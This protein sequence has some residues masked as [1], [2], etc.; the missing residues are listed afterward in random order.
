M[1]PATHTVNTSERL[2]AL[3]QL[4]SKSEYD[5]AAVVVPSEDQHYS[6]YPAKCDERRA[7][8]S[9]FTGSAGCAVITQND[10]FLFTDG[11]YFLQAEKQLDKNW[12]LMKQGLPDV[13]TWQEF[14]WKKLPKCTRIGVDPTIVTASD[15]DT[16]QKNLDP[17]ESRLVSLKHNLVDLVWTD[18]PPRPANGIFPL[19]VKYAGESHVRKIERL[20]EEMRKREVHAIVVNMLDEVAWLINLRGSDIDYNPVFFAYA[21]LTPEKAQIFLNPEQIDDAL[22]K[23]LGDDVDIHPY[24]S[25]FSYL[26]DIGAEIGLHK[27]SKALVGDKASLAIVEAMGAD[28]VIVAR[29]PVTDLKAVKNETEVEGFRQSHIRDGVALVRYFAWLEEQMNND[30]ELNECEVADQL[31]RYRSELALFR[32]LSFPTISATGSNG[33]IIHYQPD[34]NDCAIVRKDQIYLC[35]SGAQFTD[36]TTDVTRTWHFGTPTAEERRAFTRVLQG[37]IAIDTAIFPNGTTG[38]IIDSFA[39]RPLWEDGLDFRHGTGHGVG[40]FLNVHEGPHGIGVRIAYNS[41]P[42]KSGMTVSDEPGYYADGRFGIRIENV[43]VV[44]E[45]KTPNNFGQKGYLK[46]EH[47]TM[48]PIQKNLVDTSLLSPK[49]RSWL[50]TYHAEILEKLSPL[51]KTDERALTWLQR[52]CSPL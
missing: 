28:N 5:V 51:L 52:E 1:A 8:M 24:D 31:E 43:V 7:F 26:S 18:R 48:C 14:L 9:G 13:P 29:S 38:Y 41:T 27:K 46:F 12:T 17:L 19:D 45:A 50:D 10:A 15:A 22:C 4:M 21:V 25:F 16:I 35:D 47:V 30:A 20:R 44:R 33:A 23:H 34:P 11:R 6:E 36:G 49:E 40:H 32:G 39:R 2:A 42:L 3:R 37:H